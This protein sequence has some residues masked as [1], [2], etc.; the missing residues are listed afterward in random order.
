MS[1]LA[2]ALPKP[3]SAVA[4][5]TNPDSEHLLLQQQQQVSQTKKCTAPRYGQRQ[6][7]RPKKQSDFG[8]GGAYPEIHLA[9]FPQGMGKTHNNS[10]A[11]KTL[12]LQ[13]NKDGKVKYDAIVLQGKGGAIQNGKKV[14]HTTVDQ[15]KRKDILENDE[16]LVRPGEDVE[17]E[18]AEKTRQALSK[19]ID[20]KSAAAK[21]TRL[22]KDAAADQYIRYTPAQQGA[23]FNSG[24]QQ[25]IIRM[26][27]APLDPLDPPKFKIKKVPGPPPSPPPPVMHSPPRKITKE[28]HDAFNIPPCVSNWKNIKGYTVPLEKRLVDG[29]GLQE[30]EINMRFAEFSSVLTKTTQQVAEGMR[31]RREL[32]NELKRQ[33]KERKEQ[34]LLRRA[35]QAKNERAGIRIQA[36][37][38]SDESDEGDETEAQQQQQQVPRREI[39]QQQQQQDQRRQQQH[40]KQQ[41][42]DQHRRGSD[43]EESGEDNDGSLS[44]EEREKIRSERAYDR[45]RE[46]RLKKA[47]LDKQKSIKERD[48]DRDISEQ[49]AL[50]KSIKAGGG[51]GDGGDNI[52]DQRLFNQTQGLSSGF[53]GGNDDGYNIYDKPLFNTGT[54]AIYRPK[55][56]TDEMAGDEDI[57]RLKKNRFT[58]DKGFKGTQGSSSSR[59]GPVQFERDSA[60][61]DEED[62]FGLDAVL[63]D[64]IKDDRSDRSSRH[65]N[66]GKAQTMIASSS[67][68]SSLREGSGGS[69]KR[70]DM[71]PE[72]GSGRSSSDA[73]RHRRQ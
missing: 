36:P 11:G 2:G 64:A 53:D 66:I 34:E 57:A 29:R 59:D 72:S 44:R 10:N 22:C 30:K 27:E 20:Y 4:T 70:L 25:R 45:Q 3:K 52:F 47:S 67:D 17:E 7:W 71:V 65:D 43:D 73:K 9:Q 1:S 55:S 24:A 18:T 54:S 28:E 19:I 6:G 61:A 32:E 58:A 26:V 31:V 62:V 69:R 46:R 16:S 51:G 40:T 14:V 50:G 13:V 5:R 15:M 49:I 56:N 8:D 63:N 12:A 23:K 33:E 68:A 21:S 60:A 48:R 37:E 42:R 41:G 35:E 38:K 39:Q